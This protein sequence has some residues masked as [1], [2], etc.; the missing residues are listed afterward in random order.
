[1]DSLTNNTSTVLPALDRTQI[2]FE[3]CRQEAKERVEALIARGYEPREAVR[4]ARTRI[5]AAQRARAIHQAEQLNAP[6][7]AATA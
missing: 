2:Q 1:V 4:E 5:G 6:A 7:F 3:R